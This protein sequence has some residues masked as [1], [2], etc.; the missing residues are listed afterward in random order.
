MKTSTKW[1]LATVALVIVVLTAGCTSNTGNQTPSA[2]GGQ[3]PLAS[4][5]T[6]DTKNFTIQYPST[7][8]NYTYISNYTDSI[9]VDSPD[10]NAMV[11]VEY[12]NYSTNYTLSSYTAARLAANV[13][14]KNYTQI[15][16]GDATLAGNPAYKIVYTATGLF[17]TFQKFTEIFTVHNGRVYQISYTALPEK[18]DTYQD[19]AQKMIDS[20][21]IK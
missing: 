18:Y 19:T 20:F 16:A 21:Q 11:K 7:W 12:Q 1:A 4:Q 6:Y 14:N 9:T 17:G 2:A 15:S 13:S 5:I 10:R 8:T 3:A